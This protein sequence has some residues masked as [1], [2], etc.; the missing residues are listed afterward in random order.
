VSTPRDPLAIYVHWPFCKAKCPYC[1]FNSHVRES[2]EQA[3]WRDALLQEIR[4]WAESAPTGEVVSIFFGGGTPSLMPPETVAAVIDAIST[5]W[6]MHAAAEITLEANPT[7]VEA[8]KF[9]GFR[10]AGVNRL[11]LGVQ[12]LRPDAL[13]ALG[14]E[15]DVAEAK[16]AIA[17]AQAT[18]PRM[19]FDLI[20]AREGQ[21]PQEWEAE[22]EEALQLA[23][24]HLS[25]YQLT[26]EPGTQFFHRHAAGKLTLPDE[27]YSSAMFDYTNARMEAEG[28]PSYEISNYA[29]AGQESRHN[30]AYWRG[31]SYLGIGAG[32]H[33]R[34]VLNGQHAATQNL[35]SPEKWLASVQASGCAHEPDMPRI[36]S[37]DEV[38]E[39]RV[40]MGLR[41]RD[42]LDAARFQQQTGREL[43]DSVDKEAADW[44]VTNGWLVQDARGMRVT[45]QGWPL[46]NQVIA[47]LLG[48]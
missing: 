22:L 11:S 45:P 41:L 34:P 21:S 10:S 32:A 13:K 47:R 8:E 3:A 48:A 36:L 20:Y 1:D 29:C 2:V 7:S 38:V 16:A 33:G 26:I 44:L 24:G 15:H 17:L 30:L 46:V 31:E 19:S 42:G 5:H 9:R 6:P 23:A 43:Q 27:D 12:S 40:L 37:A 39:E 25:L 18:F 35:R 28:M 14:R 4:Y